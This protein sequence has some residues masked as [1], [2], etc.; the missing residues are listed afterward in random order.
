MTSKNTHCRQIIH[1]MPAYKKNKIC[2]FKRECEKNRKLVHR[3][4]IYADPVKKKKY[5][6]RGRQEWA[7]RRDAGK[8]ELISDLSR[9]EKAKQRK[10]WRNY[11]YNHRAQKKKPLTT[12]SKNFVVEVPSLESQEVSPGQLVW[13]IE[14]CFWRPGKDKEYCETG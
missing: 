7:N 13:A 1:K 11:Y 10:K 2:A 9:K 6:A 8:I 3:A 5:L 14:N 12:S 4:K